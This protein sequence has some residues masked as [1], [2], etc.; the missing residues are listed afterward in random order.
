MDTRKR[1][2]LITVVETAVIRRFNIQKEK[3]RETTRD[4]HVVSRYLYYKM[5]RSTIEF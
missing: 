3:L 1:Y 2:E 5:R 4:V